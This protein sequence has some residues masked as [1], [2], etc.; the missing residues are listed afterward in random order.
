VAPTVEEAAEAALVSR[1]TAYRYFP[2]Q[3]ALVVAAHPEIDRTSLLPDPAPTDPEERFDLV[4]G[5]HLRIVREWEPQLRA[6]WRLAL[7]PGGDPTG[8]VLRRG[9]V[10]G[11]FE[12]ALAPM[13]ADH[14]GLDV[15]RL[16]VAVRAASGIE[17]YLWLV[18]V[19]RTPRDESIEILRWNARALLRAALAGHPPPGPGSGLPAQ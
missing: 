3:R 10:I 9:R 11:W 1:T 15:H 8:P 12:D 7:E 19:A 2:N 14:P 16:A 5:E 4:L 17:A 13:R 18:D 6:S